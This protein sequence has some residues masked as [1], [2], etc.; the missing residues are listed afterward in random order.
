[1]DW[2]S[3]PHSFKELIFQQ[4]VD[5]LRIITAESVWLLRQNMSCALTIPAHLSIV[6][7]FKQYPS[8]FIHIYKRYE[9][10]DEDCVKEYQSISPELMLE[11]IRELLKVCCFHLLLSNSTVSGI[12]LAHKTRNCCLHFALQFVSFLRNQLC[13]LYVIFSISLA[14]IS[15][16]YSISVKSDSQSCLRCRKECRSQWL[17]IANSHFLL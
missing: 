8:F 1:M 13:N 11:V 2:I 5:G 15:R 3:I 16:F 4:E 9:A 14:A 12:I 6:K 17:N 7:Q 10:G